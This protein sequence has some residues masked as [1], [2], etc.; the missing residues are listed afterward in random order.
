MPALPHDAAAAAAHGPATA[1]AFAI[2]GARLAW[3]SGTE[4]GAALRTLFI[5]ALAGLIR[6]ALRPDDGDPAFQALVLR[7]QQAEV[8][9]HV[10]LAA[11]AEADRRGVM[12]VLDA[13]AHPGKLRQMAPGARREAL[14]SL[15][16]LARDHAW[17]A[18]RT[19]AAELLSHDLQ[20]SHDL[21]DTPRLRSSLASLLQQPGLARLE[22]GLAL[23]S[24]PA[25]I[26]YEDLC[27]RSGPAAGTEAGAAKGAAAARRGSTAE[28]E[29]V[30]ALHRLAAAIGPRGP[31]GAGCR[32]ASRLLV[33]AGF[34]G[35]ADKAKSEWDAAL[36]HEAGAGAAA[37]VAL[38]V[39]VKASSDAA[40]SD[41]PR[42][43]AG[44]QRLAQARSEAAYD[45]RSDQGSWRIG[46]A[47]LR[48][49]Q[50]AGDALPPQVIYCSTAPADAHVPM[51]SAASRGVL[52]TE[53]ASLAFAAALAGGG[54]P[55]PDQLGPVWTEL[56][57]AARLR[58]VLHQYDIARIVRE[59]ML[60]PHD[61]LA[62]AEAG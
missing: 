51:L 45:F 62:A 10:R 14:A 32:V 40:V 4:P 56:G 49:L 48:Q 33:P 53:R 20:H 58:A 17:P 2:E 44:L 16:R 37:D 46:G 19:A 52:L 22:R 30:Q 24:A 39:E 28:A 54:S 5:E 34:P 9:E 31:G 27:A 57:S 55:D 15:H 11:Q 1:A 8:D 36:V 47:S 13:I 18:L 50:P 25:V 21:D 6:I 7:A 41:F 59:A 23:R 38:L 35:P 29:V 61:L 12:A 3:R 60:H 42:L 26:R 43:M